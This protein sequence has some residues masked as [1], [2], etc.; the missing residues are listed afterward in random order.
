[1]TA[2]LD[3]RAIVRRNA[4]GEFLADLSSSTGHKA[5]AIAGS[6]PGVSGG[7][8][9]LR[10]FRNKDH[11]AATVVVVFLNQSIHFSDPPCFVNFRFLH[12][13]IPLKATV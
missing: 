8:L 10:S 1:M 6:I 12:R 13:P 9:R 7:V 2:A 4:Q 11:F 3:H 5:R